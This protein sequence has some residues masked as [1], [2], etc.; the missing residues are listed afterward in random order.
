MRLS[1]L[2]CTLVYDH[3]WKMRAYRGYRRCLELAGIVG[4]ELEF[5][6]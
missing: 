1:E 5:N 3:T 4:R 6:R 2:V